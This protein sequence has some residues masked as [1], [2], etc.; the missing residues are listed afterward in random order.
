MNDFKATAIPFSSQLWSLLPRIL[1]SEVSVGRER[2]REGDS[3]GEMGRKERD[4]GALK[5]ALVVA[6]GLALAWITMEAAFKPWLDR[7]RAAIARSD[8]AADPDDANTTSSSALEPNEGEND[9]DG[10]EE[11]KIKEAMES[12]N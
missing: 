10:V 9:T 12:S 7:L 1:S 6:G 5:S 4:G 8:P 3:D 2:R 11:V